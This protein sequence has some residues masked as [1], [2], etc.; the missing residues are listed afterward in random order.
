MKNI[1]FDITT[2]EEELTKITGLKMT[3]FESLD[4]QFSKRWI[5]YFKQN[6]LDGQPRL[7]Q[8]SS[9]KNNIFSTGREALLFGL[10]YLKSDLPQEDIAKQ[11]GIDQPK[12]SR[13]LNLICNLLRQSVE[14]R[15]V[16]PTKKQQ[17]LYKQLN[18]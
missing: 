7:R 16:L 10:I 18:Q 4:S 1:F 12:A 2:K 13:Y 11:Y 9:R 6:T 5:S 3:E 17:W 15:R 8:S 14:K